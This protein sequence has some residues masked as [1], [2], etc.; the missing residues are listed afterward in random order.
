MAENKD[1]SKSRITSCYVKANAKNDPVIQNIIILVQNKYT[2]IIA[3]LLP[4]WREKLD[5]FSVEYNGLLYM[6][7]C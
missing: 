7:H 1:L 4:P 6:D 3:R 5:S 2:A